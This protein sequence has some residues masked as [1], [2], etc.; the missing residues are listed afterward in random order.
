MKGMKI[1]GEV[2]RRKICENFMSNSSFAKKIG[3]NRCTITA[4]VQEHRSPRPEDIPVMAKVLGCK[5]EELI[6]RQEV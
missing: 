5:P 4:Y 3:K 6:R 1:N 2:L